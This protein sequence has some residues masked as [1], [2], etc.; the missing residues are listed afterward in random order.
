MDY[1]SYQ[2]EQYNNEFFKWCLEHKL[3][4]EAE[5]FTSRI[6]NIYIEER[7]Y[8]SLSVIIASDNNN[9][10][11]IILCE[12]K[13]LSHQA[14]TFKNPLNRNA[15]KKEVFDWEIINLGFLSIYVKEE[16][17]NKGLA[18]QLLQ[19]MEELRL[20][21]NIELIAKKNCVILFEGKEKT[22]NLANK[23]LN[24]SYITDCESHNGNY[25]YELHN[26]TAGILEKRRNEFSPMYPL[27]DR[28]KI[29]LK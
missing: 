20:K 16:Y 21:N 1:S 19:Q 4:K 26:L 28:K 15:N 7:E 18:T 13:Q 29:K 17:R 23:H 10:T 27:P 11:A 22:Y 24:Y 8:E 14:F 9:P 3:F 25:I 12:N 5:G 6:K 2:I